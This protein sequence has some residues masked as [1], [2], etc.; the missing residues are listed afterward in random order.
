[1]TIE[2]AP[3][4]SRKNISITVEDEG[5]GIPDNKLETI[6][7]RFYTERPEHEAFGGHSGLGLSICRQ[8]VTAMGGRIFA[9]NV[10]DSRG[11]ILGAR[12]T[13]ILNAA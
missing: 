5:P 2:I 11:E 13:I 3:S 12:F 9:E 6:F 8:I 4:P 10:R 7:E 1:M